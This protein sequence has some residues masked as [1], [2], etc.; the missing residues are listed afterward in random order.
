VQKIGVDRERR[1][2][3]LI[4]GDRDLMLLGELD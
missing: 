4:L 3:A 1:L 2:A